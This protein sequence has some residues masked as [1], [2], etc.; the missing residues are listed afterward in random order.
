MTPD[1]KAQTLVDDMR[2]AQRIGQNIMDSH[3]KPTAKYLMLTLLAD[4]IG[5]KVAPLTPCKRGCDHCC[6]IAVGISQH[7][8]DRIGAVTGRQPA[9]LRRSPEA[10]ADALDRAQVDN[11]GKPCP[12]LKDHA[13]TVYEVRPMACRA[14]HSLADTAENCDSTGRTPHNCPTV[15]T[16]SV[17]HAMQEA[18]AVIFFD[19][20]VFG[21]IREFF[22]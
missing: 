2:E 4:T 22:P 7:E 9:D 16:L 21:D 20:P 10:I 13:C 14:H 12:F 11:Y 19:D 5:E 17:S 3:A 18:S 8:A 1:E 6:R 15:P